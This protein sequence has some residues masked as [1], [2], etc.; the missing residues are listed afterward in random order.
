MASDWEELPR[1]LARTPQIYRLKVQ[2]LRMRIDPITEEVSRTIEIEGN[3]TLYDL[4]MAIQ[5]VFDWDNDHLFSFYT[6]DKLYDRENE[7]AG[8]PM[9]FHGGVKIGKKTSA[10]D[11]E[12]R[13]L[14]LKEASTLLYLFDYG[15]ELVHQV[16]VEEIRDKTDEDG[17]RFKLVA[18]VGI[19]P[20]QYDESW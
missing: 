18:E 12:I 13:D 7:Y 3:K 16:L 10:D 8:N 5:R 2:L 15:D 17:D 11:V 14:D 9:E 1:L 6:G 4:H 20:P 19:V